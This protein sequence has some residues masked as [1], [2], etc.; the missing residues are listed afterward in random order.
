MPDYLLGHGAESEA[1]RYR[2]HG[3]SR[4][5]AACFGRCATYSP[6]L[7]RLPKLCRSRHDSH[8]SLRSAD[9]M[10]VPRLR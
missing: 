2:V 3:N 5:G 10:E 8:D 9:A 7:L 1:G 6:V 4:H